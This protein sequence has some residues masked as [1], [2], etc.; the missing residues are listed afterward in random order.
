MN[1]K[2]S[3]NP[4]IFKG[5][6]NFS[7][8]LDFALRDHLQQATVFKGTSKEIQNDLIECM[9]SVC[10]AHIKEEI[11]T[12]SFVFIISDETTDISNIFQMVIVYRYTLANGTPVER[13]WSFIEPNNHALALASCI[14]KSLNYALKNSD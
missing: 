8:E 9:L 11:S 6:V 14:E 3:L 4:G 7:T 12:S 2:V 1:N 13:F 5:L 10:Q